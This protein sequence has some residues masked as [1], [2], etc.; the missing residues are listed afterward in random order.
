MEFMKDF[1]LEVYF[2]KYEFSVKYNIGGSDTQTVTISDLIKLCNDSERNRWEKLSLGYTETLGASALREEIAKT[3]DNMK[4]DNILCFA[5]AE[6]GIFSVM[7]A[8]L[9]KD[10]H[11]LVAYPNY[12]SSETIPLGI[13]EVGGIPLD[14][15]KNWDMD[16]DFVRDSIKPNTKLISIN[17]PNNPTGKVMNR[18]QYRELVEL[19]RERGIWLFSD[20][21]YRLMER[22]DDIRLTQ[23]ADIY[24]KAIS[25]N[26]M[27]KAYGM[28]GLRIGWIAS[29]D[30]EILEKSK[31]VKHWLSICNSGPSEFLA[32]IALRNRDVILGRNRKIVNNNLQ[33][34]NQF[35]ASHADLFEWVEP[36]GGCVG[37]PRYKSDRPVE[38]FV[39]ELVT[40]LGILFL[41]STI[42][43]S[44]L[45][46]TPQDRFRVG[47]GKDYFIEALDI[48]DD[49]L[50]KDR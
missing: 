2:A 45:G 34:L 30:K 29:Q 41:P 26:V 44:D 28:A 36:D 16:L 8:L 14:P 22:S 6:E 18:K 5:G 33:R 32:A 19:C 46:H 10:D 9:D 40:N 11:A 4:A 7:N 48:L 50:K 35:F 39:D 49:H 38:Q 20:E 3:Y 25:L 17:F 47:F 21:V 13:C 43:R 24:E 37:Y 27:S 1:A 23:A 12:Q 31:R 15:N 42:F